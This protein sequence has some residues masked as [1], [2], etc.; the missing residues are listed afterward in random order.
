MNKV[1]KCKTR[2]TA[3]FNDKCGKV[4][5]GEGCSE[6]PAGVLDLLTPRGCVSRS[7]GGEL[8]EGGLGGHN[9]ADITNG[10]GSVELGG[11]DEDVGSFVAESGEVCEAGNFQTHGFPKVAKYAIDGAVERVVPVAGAEGATRGDTKEGVIAVVVHR[12]VASGTC[13]GC[14]GGVVDW[15]ED[16]AGESNGELWVLESEVR[17]V[18]SDRE[19]MHVAS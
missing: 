9:C 19:R 2:S 10:I 5:R 12:L 15:L 16:A 7:G 6:F 14:E 13:E 3:V 17:K 4:F 8:D 1:V 11:V 18:R